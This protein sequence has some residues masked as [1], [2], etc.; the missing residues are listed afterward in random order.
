[1]EIFFNSESFPL[2]MSH[3]TKGVLFNMHFKRAYWNTGWVSEL[4]RLLRLDVSIDTVIQKDW[5]S[6]KHKHKSYQTS[7]CYTWILHV[8]IF[9]RALIRFGL[10]RVALIRFWLLRVALIRFGLLR[11]A[12]IRFW[13][14]R[15]AHKLLYF[16]RL[17]VMWSRVQT[18]LNHFL[19]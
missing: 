12:L 14:L 4:D 13:L 17:I 2:S 16:L 3:F 8:V 5:E 15:V 7:I 9:M 1:L 18:S 19:R 11:V 10:L 6:S